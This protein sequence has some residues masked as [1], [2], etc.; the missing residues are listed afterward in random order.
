MYVVSGSDQTELRT[1]FAQRHISTIFNG[2]IYGSPKSKYEIIDNLLL[3]SP[4]DKYSLFIGDSKLDYEVASHYSM[5]FV[6]V[7]NWTEFRSLN[8]FAR[9]NSIPVYPSLSDIFYDQ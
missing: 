3:N 1:V 5:D 7:S 4:L 8:D 2:G 6:F 9:L